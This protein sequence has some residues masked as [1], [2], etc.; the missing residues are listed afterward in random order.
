MNDKL[1]RFCCCRLCISRGD[2][3]NDPHSCES[4]AIAVGSVELAPLLFLPGS[5][6]KKSPAV[7][8]LL[9]SQ[10]WQTYSEPLIGPGQTSLPDSQYPG[11]AAGL[12]VALPA[13]RAEP[14]PWEGWV[15]EE[16]SREHGGGPEPKVTGP[17]QGWLHCL[18]ELLWVVFLF[19]SRRIKW[20]DL[21]QAI[22]KEGKGDLGLHGPGKVPVAH[23]VWNPSC[24]WNVIGKPWS[25][26]SLVWT[27]TWCSLCCVLWQSHHVLISLFKAQY[28]NGCFYNP[29]FLLQFGNVTLG[30]AGVFEGYIYS[31]LFL[32]SE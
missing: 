7:I 9:V 24:E 23:L 18:T 27:K 5:L 6:R 32:F 12:K 21:K 16:T 30:G 26:N 31:P 2:L 17:G 28:S 20:S 14:P 1:G 25:L 19:S 10:V 15:T 11:S 13:S 29:E 3:Q 4:R 22:L 8:R